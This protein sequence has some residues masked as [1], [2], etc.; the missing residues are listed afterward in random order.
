MFLGENSRSSN[1][2]LWNRLQF[3]RNKSQRA[4]KKALKSPAKIK[5]PTKILP[6]FNSAN[7]K[8]GD[9]KV[10]K[11]IIIRSKVNFPSRKK[12]DG[13]DECESPPPP[14]LQERF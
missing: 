3:Q 10:K 5:S 6:D 7:S 11:G 8:V 9:Y 1:D 12:L 13:S 2:I 4:E 14:R